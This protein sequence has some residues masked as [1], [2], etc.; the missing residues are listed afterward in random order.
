MKPKHL[1]KA[2][3]RKQKLADGRTRDQH[4]HIMETHIGRELGRHEVVHHINGDK[5]DNRIE[6][7]EVMSLSEHSKMH[8]K[9]SNNRYVSPEGRKKI[10][11]LHRGSKNKSA[12]LTES[13]VMEIKEALGRGYGVRY[14]GRMYGVSHTRISDIKNHKTW[15]HVEL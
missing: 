3:Y 12:K 13:L 2:K 14:L 6:N 10:G 8:M 5:Y 11:D 4:R 9:V 1:C 15:V 7:L